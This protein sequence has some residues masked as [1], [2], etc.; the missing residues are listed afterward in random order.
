MASNAMEVLK[1][2]R[3]RRYLE[4]QKWE[5]GLFTYHGGENWSCRTKPECWELQVT[6]GVPGWT[7]III[8]SP[9]VIMVGILKQ[10]Y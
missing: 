10:E 7:E 4:E 5:S 6:C 8:D 9:P 1:T 3:L 2:G